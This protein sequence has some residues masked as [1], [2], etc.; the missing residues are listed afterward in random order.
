MSELVE[1]VARALCSRRIK[2][3]GIGDAMPDSRDVDLRWEIFTP[4]ARAAIKVVA[5]WLESQHYLTGA[6]ELMAQL[7]AKP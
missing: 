3:V 5:E 6:T 4:E 7:E 1:K 2:E